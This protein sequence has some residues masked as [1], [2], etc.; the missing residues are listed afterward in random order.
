MNDNSNNFKR[1]ISKL[2]LN[3]AVGI[4]ESYKGDKPF[5][6]FI[7]AFFA[8]NKKYGA[9]D[10]KQVSSLC[11]Y[12]FRLGKAAA[13]LSII[14][15]ITLATFL[16]ENEP[17]DFL[18][19]IKPIWN[20]KVSQPINK[21]LALVKKEFDITHIF[22]F[23]DALSDDINYK[24]FCQSFLI[25]PDLFLRVRPK[26][27]LGVLKKLEKLKPAHKL[28]GEDCIALPNATKA[29]EFFVLDK[30]V[31]VQDYNSQKVLDLFKPQNATFKTP[32]TT[33]WDCCAASGGKSILL[34]DIF[35]QRISLTV[36]DIRPNIILNLHPRFSKTGIKEYDYFIADLASPE[37]KKTLPEEQQKN[38]KPSIIICDAPCTG[39]GTWSR[40]PEQLHFFN[41][42]KT[43]EYSNR[44]KQIV[45][46]VI[47][48]MQKDSLFVYI[49]CSVFKKENE[50]V[51]DFIKDKFKITLVQKELLKGYDK[52]ADSMFVAVFRK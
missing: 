36:S 12:Y 44:Q 21:K 20:S 14:D 9:R 1:Y 38:L 4:I 25:Q 28:L 43:D 48:F 42:K 2:H 49:T 45:S 29:E 46:N 51:V 34:F 39:S 40:S 31:V 35:N 19:N 33:V 10:R 11:Y 50:E 15:K 5:A 30:E 24:L 18:E 22:P 13:E 16:C 26:V 23:A 41:A 52:K 27:R 37:F 8:E 6:L 47:P 3:A 32:L 17:S 7:K